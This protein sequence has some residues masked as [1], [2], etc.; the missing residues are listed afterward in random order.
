[1]KNIIN[2]FGLPILLF[3]GLVSLICLTFFSCKSDYLDR[4]PETTGYDFETVF[5]DST[6]YWKFCEFLVVNPLF[7]HLQDGGKPYGTWDDA[8][9]NSMGTR[10]S[11]DG[12]PIMTQ[13]GDWYR[14][15][16]SGNQANVCN[17]NT[18]AA[19]WRHLR[20]AN[21]GLQNIEHYPGSE[22]TKNRILGL[23]Y[24]YRAY[25]YM[26]LCR[27]WGG[28]PYLY[29]PLL[30]T[31]NM[32]LPRLSMQ[33]TYLLAAE[34][35]D[36]AA[37][38]LQARVPDDQFQYPTKIAA[39]ALKS[40]CIL[41]AASKQARDE[42]HPSNPH[43]DLWEKAAIAADEAI[44]AAEGLV[45]GGVN[46]HGLVKWDET[47]M[48]N[49]DITGN[50]GYYYIF[51]GNRKEHLLKEVLFGRRQRLG[52]DLATYKETFRPPGKL[53]GVLG[54]AVNQLLVD[55]FEM[56]ATGL[57][58]DEPGSGYVEQNPYVGRDPRFY[59]NIAYNGCTV[60]TKKLDIWSF[61]EVTGKA[62][63]E[64]MADGA[65]GQQGYTTS[66]TYNRKMMGQDFGVNLH[67]CWP[68]IRMAELYLNFAEAANEAWSNPTVVDD[69]CTYSAEGAIN[70]IRNRAM[71]PNIDSR[72]LTKDKFRDRVR[73]ERRI[74]LCWEEHRTFDIRRWKIGKE[75]MNRDFYKISITKLASGPTSEYPTGFKFGSKT[76][77]LSRSWYDDK[78]DLFVIPRNDTRLGPNF[79]QNPGW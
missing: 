30:S 13:T 65:N 23:C 44:K 62:D 3:C 40:R 2:F 76:I 78:H 18:W 47:D 19:M 6:N 12:F 67:W 16:N 17:E 68:Y 4:R 50:R 34:D 35:F 43:S 49:P 45:V 69:R 73:N 37:E 52:W 8:S 48:I 60:M 46:Y 24:F 7:L 10:Y 53:D 11:G 75:P 26:E 77:H 39:L 56:Q 20:V 28:M 9:D 33:E 22:A 63:S 57:P 59:H 27:R 42:N 66:G 32:D 64:D 14:L 55:C 74:E 71:M 15:S 70:M 29:K 72:Y 31:D 79:N 61:N 41:Y 36:N 51:K 58:I 25:V 5:A 38:Y 21:T 1:M 54:N